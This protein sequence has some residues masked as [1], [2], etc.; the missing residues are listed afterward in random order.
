MISGVAPIDNAIFESLLV[1]WEALGCGVTS[2]TV[3]PSIVSSAPFNPY[4]FLNSSSCIMNYDG[5][6]TT[7]SCDEIV[8]WNLA[9]TPF[10]IS[11]T[12][13]SRMLTLINDCPESISHSGSTSRPIQPL[14][15][16]T[17]NNICPA[18]RRNLRGDN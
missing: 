4:D 2:G 5:G 14:N 11:S 16:R 1:G 3:N 9:T 13:M 7:P 8:E 6:L 12:Q 17:L 10:S 15:G 18:S